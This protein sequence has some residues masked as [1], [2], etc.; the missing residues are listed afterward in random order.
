LNPKQYT[1]KLKLDLDLIKW[2]VKVEKVIYLHDWLFV[3]QP[4]SAA[5]ISCLFRAKT[6]LFFV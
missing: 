3:A 2:Y 6:N 5:H 4:S 1:F